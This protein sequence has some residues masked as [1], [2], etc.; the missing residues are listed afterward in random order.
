MRK[1]SLASVLLITGLSLSSSNA[2]AIASTNFDGRTATGNT[3]SVLNWTLDGV[4]DPGTMSSTVFGG[5]AVNLFDNTADNQDS[6]VPALNTGNG[7]SSWTTIINLTALAGSLVTVEDITFDYLSMNGGGAI[8]VA[9]K[10]DFAVTLFS[11]ANVPL[12]TA[13]ID[14]VVSG[15]NV[16]PIIAPVSLTLSNPVALTDPGTY[17]LVFRGGDF[18][19][20]NETGNHTGIDNLA[21]NGTVGLVPEPSTA[22]LSVMA[23]LGFVFFRRRK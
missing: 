17:T 8:N 12:A 7:N 20:D 11:P 1:K 2:V 5:G 19:G 15:T 23:V 22:L 10:S 4:S 13:S 9:R 14:D 18:S 3:A 6:F 21:I 16:V